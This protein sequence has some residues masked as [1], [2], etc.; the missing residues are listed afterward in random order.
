MR[1]VKPLDTL[2]LDTI[3][4]QYEFI[5]TVEDGCI[6]GGFGSAVLEYANE[7]RY[8]QTIK[9]MGIPDRFLDHGTQENS[10]WKQGSM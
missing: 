9:M 6:S 10:T 3:F 1:F 4:R 8:E 2:Q 7:M 5:I